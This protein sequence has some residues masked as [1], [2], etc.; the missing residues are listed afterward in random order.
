MGN[1]PVWEEDGCRDNVEGRSRLFVWVGN[2]SGIITLP[3][4]ARGQVADLNSSTTERC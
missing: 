3:A 1:E 4:G 2:A